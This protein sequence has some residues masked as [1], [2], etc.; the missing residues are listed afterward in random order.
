MRFQE[1]GLPNNTAIKNAYAIFERQL[2]TAEDPRYKHFLT[3]SLDTARVLG[4]YAPEAILPIVTILVSGSPPD[5]RPMLAKRL[6]QADMLKLMEEMLHH[7]QT[8][9]SYIGDG[10]DDAKL[11][12][13]A[14]RIY[15]LRHFLKLVHEQ[16]TK[17]LST[18][19][20]QNM[21]DDLAN[22]PPEPIGIPYLSNLEEHK[23]VSDL[24]KGK[25]SS[26]A[27]EEAYAQ[28]VAQS[29][30]VN[31]QQKKTLEEMNVQTDPSMTRG[32]SFPR[33]DDSALLDHPTV[34]AAYDILTHDPRVDPASFAIA[35]E[36]AEALS[37][38]SQ[39][40]NPAVIAAALLGIGVPR[41]TS[42]DFDAWEASIGS[43]A[44]DTLMEGTIYEHTLLRKLPDASENFKQI[45]AAFV[46]SNL[47]VLEMEAVE[48]A[49]M[50]ANQARHIYVAMLQ[51]RIR[52]MSHLEQ[53]LIGKTGDQ[54]LEMLMQENLHH[55]EQRISQLRPTGGPQPPFPGKGM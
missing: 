38:A 31:E 21:Q 19:F 43:E 50:P 44:T 51:Q 52:G 46:A 8:N 16:E 29:E 4:E 10:T 49:K 53:M 2:S 5:A 26:P 32:F 33:F 20:N 22:M 17:R 9:L 41:A 47:Y 15:G 48:L 1:T 55:A 3:A 36:A 54:E 28:I 30:E 40:K 7:H 11:I 12:T 13:L 25:T 14:S 23:R 18:M 34:R 37:M 42:K 39:R 6:G 27:L 24:L 45:V 35:I